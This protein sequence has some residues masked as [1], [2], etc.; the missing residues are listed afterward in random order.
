MERLKFHMIP[1]F[2]LTLRVFMGTIM[3]LINTSTLEVDYHAVGTTGMMPNDKG[4]VLDVEMKVCGTFINLH[5]MDTSILPYQVCE[6]LTSTLNAVAE[7][8]ST[9]IINGSA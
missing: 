2:E 5:A 4:G 9:I 6:H 7:R 3:R 1:Y 8:L